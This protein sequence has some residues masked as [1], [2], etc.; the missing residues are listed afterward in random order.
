MN[1]YG[2]SLSPVRQHERR[3]RIGDEWAEPETDD[4]MVFGGAEGVTTTRVL[5]HVVGGATPGSASASSVSVDY[6]SMVLR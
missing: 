4:A 5:Q 6:P 3:R 2:I 1:T